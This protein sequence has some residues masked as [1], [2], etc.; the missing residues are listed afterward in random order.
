MN[1]ADAIDAQLPETHLARAL[2]LFSDSSG[3]RAAAAIREVRAA[4]Q[5]APS[6]GHH[7]LAGLYNH[8]GLEDLAER[9]FQKAFE[10]D[11]TSSILAADYVAYYYLLHRPD[12]LIA[13]VRKY[14][15][16]D[17]LPASYHMMKGELQ[18]ARRRIDELAASKPGGPDDLTMA[19][20]LG[21]EGEKK[22]SEEL[23]AKA[24]S[25]FPAPARRA[26]NYHHF[27]YEIACVY[28]IN[29]N[30]HGAMKWLRE[31]AEKGLRS[32]TLFA[33][34]PFLDKIRRLPEFRQF[35]GDMRVEH[36]QLRNEFYH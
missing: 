26:T 17:P 27:T 20:L 33:R 5:F 31:S 18:A 28:A 13:A 22:G 32:Y 23:L 4:Q 19:Y 8:I 11:P 30:G 16:E 2:V 7:D 35:I 10:I 24:I 12:E 9:E 3:Y 25:T 6:I 15:P 36:E 29:G 34:D 1:R 14:F 21:L